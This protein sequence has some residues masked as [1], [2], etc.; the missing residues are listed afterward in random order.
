MVKKKKKKIGKKEENTTFLSHY[1]KAIFLKK[2]KKKNLKFSF[3]NKICYP[4]FRLSLLL[5]ILFM[6]L[7][8][9]NSTWLKTEANL[10]LSMN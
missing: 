3:L 2:K 5:P 9:P 6:M 1:N 4:I 7:N 10:L 8:S